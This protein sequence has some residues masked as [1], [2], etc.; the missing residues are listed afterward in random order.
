MSTVLASDLVEF[1]ACPGYGFKTQPQYLVKTVMREE[2]YERS[3]RC[4]SRPLLVLTATP[5]G[6]RDEEVIQSVL[7]FWH[8]MGGRATHFLF[9][10]WTD[11]KSCQT[12]EDVTALDQPLVAVTLDDASIAY[13][14]V[15]AYTVSPH[16][17]L[18]EITK[19]VGSTIVVAN[20]SDAVQTDFDVDEASGLIK[21]GGS[22][23]GTPTKWGGEFNVP[24]RFDSELDVK[25]SDQ[26]IESV[27]FTLCE[28][29]LSLAKTFPGSP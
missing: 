16:V 12:H 24:V 4:W 22:F 15:K 9:K 21:P 2:G 7:Y 3:N 5:V 19:P 8:A 25:I 11:F 14:L 23:T 20:G 29:R 10:D 6:D 27:A 26:R 1:P 13:R 17:Q 18:R 28:K